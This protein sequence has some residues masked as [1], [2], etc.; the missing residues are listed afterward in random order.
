MSTSVRKG[1]RHPQ[2]LRLP[3]DTQP[4]WN[5]LLHP[6]TGRW[7]GQLLDVAHKT[8]ARF[9]HPAADGEYVDGHPAGDPLE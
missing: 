4:T 3:E 5:T 7:F 2:A 9:I 1:R 6:A 8:H